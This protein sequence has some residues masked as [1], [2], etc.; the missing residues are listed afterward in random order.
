M[1][2]ERSLRTRLRS[3]GL[4]TRVVDAAWPAWWSSTAEESPS[5]VAELH[6]TLARQLGLSPSSLL[7]DGEPKFL[8]R[9]ETKFKNLGT[10]S[11]RE[12]AILAS[13]SVSV[14]RCAFA[15]T[16]DAHQRPLPAA[17]FELR[18][19]MLGQWEA[20]GLRELV[21]LCWGS[22][23]PVLQLKVFPLRQKRMHAVTARLGDRH[24]ILVGRESRYPAQVAYWIAH[25]LGHIASKHVADAAAL[26]D[27]ED[28]LRSSDKDDEERG[29][30]A[31]AL[32][33]LT[34]NAAPVI[35]PTAT[36]FSA[37]QVAHAV[38]TAGPK[39]RVDP[40]V[41]ALCLGHS[42]ATWREVFGALKILGDADVGSLINDAARGQLDWSALTLDSRTFLDT[43][44]SDA[45]A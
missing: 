24:A 43:I 25:E 20:I 17:A 26:V 6:Y 7:D 33:V 3:T 2:V 14:A 42:R 9:D 39:L 44:L 10:T 28:P 8:W 30:D 35:E 21:V 34:G 40:G 45:R 4:T 31:Y 18:S 32:E 41:L 19:T 22:G 1:S 38:R 11:D 37:T 36:K 23:I 29:A 27:V 13:F 15:A 5:A 16:P 12:A